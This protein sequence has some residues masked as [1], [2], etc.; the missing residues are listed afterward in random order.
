MGFK[1]AIPLLP[2]RVPV[3]LDGIEKL[4][5]I[6]EKEN[7]DSVL[8]ITDQSIRSFGITK[9]LEDLLSSKSIKLAVY[10]KTVPNP[11]DINVNE[12]LALYKE[13]NCK[14]LIG[15]GGGSSM[16]CAKAVGALV[17]NPNKSLLKM[18]G[19]LK[20][21]KPIVPLFAIPTTAGTGSETTLAAVITDSETRHKYVINSFPLIPK[22]AVLD[23]E[24]T[25]TLPKSL[26]AT[27][28][29]DALTHAIEAYIGRSTTK[30]TREYSEK[31]I[32]LIFE[33]I[34]T[35]Y[36]DGNNLEARKNMLYASYLAGSAFTVSYVGYVHAVAHSLG[37]KYNT[38]HGL[39]NAV[40]LPYVL[41]A[42]GASVY[43][44][45]YKLALITGIAD[46]SDSYEAG[47]KKFID[48][49]WKMQDEL[50]I[51]KKIKGIEKSDIPE[52]AMHAEKEGNP[53]YPVPKLMTEKELEQ[54]Y[55]DVME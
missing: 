51:P 33:N 32:K 55:Y 26:T 27:T 50:N 52:L 22:Y 17:S 21:R 46:N 28:G 42:Y 41:E 31:A 8:L 4:P 40:L 10:D 14:A 39:A 37:G 38:P 48:A 18:A 49:I 23:A 16:D 1:V 2:Y 20:I 54:F 19:I 9:P 6:F 45:L 24:A 36:E 5:S 25:R 47:A 34:K 13:N 15:F 35:A 7:I 43:K 11:T 44:K 12:A 3:H 29:M 53:L 30:D